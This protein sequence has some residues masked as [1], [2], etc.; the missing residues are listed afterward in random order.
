M[1]FRYGPLLNDGVTPDPFANNSSEEEEFLEIG[2]LLSEA[3][4][5]GPAYWDE[6]S[7]TLNL[8]QQ[9]GN[10][11]QQ[12]VCEAA[13]SCPAPTASSNSYLQDTRDWFALHG[14]GNKGS[15]NILMADGSVAE[16]NDLD[17]DKFL[18]PGF[19]VPTNLTETEYGQLGYSS[20]VTEL[21]A[22]RMCKALQSRR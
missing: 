14:G 18:N 20:S 11:T 17:G 3:F 5:D 19:P 8:I 22:G 7:N 15:A 6:S 12:A 9:A 1:D 13:G 16:F 4:N 2:D 21:P 10:L